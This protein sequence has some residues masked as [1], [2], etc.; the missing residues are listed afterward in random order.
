MR[1]PKYNNGYIRWN[2]LGVA[3]FVAVLFGGL[4]LQFAGSD[5]KRVDAATG[6]IDALNVGTC[7]AT[8]DEVFEEEPCHLSNRSD[9]WEIRDE[10]EEVSTLYATY[11]HDPKTGWDEPRAILQDSDLLKVSISDPGRD[12]RSPVLV[13]GEGHT[14]ITGGLAEIKRLLV[15]RDLID[16]DDSVNFESGPVL[17]IRGFPSPAQIDASGSHTLNMSGSSSYRPMDVDGNIRFFGCV[18][19]AGSCVLGSGADDEL[20]DISSSLP[21]DEDRSSGSNSPSIAPWLVVNASVPADRN[22]LIYAM[23]YETSGLE[24]MVGGSS[25][26]HCGTSSNEPDRNRLCGNSP[27]N[28]RDGIG[29]VVYTR[30][31][32][33]GNDEL[34]LRVSSDGVERDVNLYLSETGLFTGRYEGY[35]RLTD[36][37]GDGTE[38]DQSGSSTDWGAKVRHGAGSRESDAAVIGVAS[39]PVTIEYRDSGGRRQS[40][41]IAIDYEPPRI[42]IDTPRH[43]SSSDDHSPDFIGSFEDYDSGLAQDSFRL[44]VDNDADASRNSDFALDRI[45]PEASV[46]GTGTNGSVSRR[47]DYI[48]YRTSSDDPFGVVDPRRLFDLG[49]DSCRNQNICYISAD[50]Y[51][52]GASSGRFDDSVRLRLDSDDLEFGVDFQAFVVDL[53]GNVGFSDS[54]PD[55]PYFINDLGVEDPRERNEPNVLGYYSAHIF[56]LDEKDPE[57]STTRSAT[58]YYGVDFGKQP[59]EPIADRRGVML[60]FDGPI[61]ASSITLDTFYVELDD[62]SEAEVVDVTVHEQYVFLKLRH[63]L[64]SD[65]TPFVGIA[66][67]ESVRDRAGNITSGREQRRVEANDGISPNLTITLSGGSGSGEGAEGPGQLTNGL[68]NIRVESDEPLQGAPRIVVVCENLRWEETIRGRKIEYDVDDFIA[69]RRGVFISKPQEDSGTRYMCGSGD[70]ATPFQ[71]QEVQGNARPGEVWEFGWSNSRGASGRLEDGRLRVVAFARDRSRYE[72]ADKANKDVQSWGAVSATFRLDRTFES[73]LKPSGGNVHPSDASE[74]SEPRP[75]IILEFAEST[76]VTLDSVTLDGVEIAD[77]FQSPDVNRFVYWPLSMARG[78]H[79]IEVEATDAAG[80]SVEFDFKFESTQRGDFVLNFVTGWNAI[81]LPA[82]PVDT[83]IDAVFTDPAIQAVVGWDTEGW[84]VAIRRDGVW[85]SNEMFGTLPSVRA[86]Y[87][88]WVKSSSF[89]SQRV[90]LR[91]PVYRV[92]GAVPGLTD[93]PTAAGWNFV[94]VIDI[95]GDQTEDHFGVTLRDSQNNPVSARDYLGANFIRAY[96]WDATFNRFEVLRP[97]DTMTIGDGVWVYFS[98]GTGIA[99]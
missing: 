7:L 53:A 64:A 74:V 98:D 84:R 54:D 43:L 81:S 42:T 91:G 40:L 63:E 69:N 17:T 10:V 29:D 20:T 79:E 71:L 1:I 14:E 70:D 28:E 13:L 41:R 88:Y 76:T 49:D 90:A 67:G 77:E 55:N 21:V 93:I 62:G 68:I 24:K 61:S 96:T 6:V 39:G 2:L 33:N 83:H 47:A 8:D 45:A 48:G 38:I 65:A 89:V 46:S 58:G 86:R 25:Y 97:S 36:A 9:G 3:I 94:G 92:E 27:A 26:Y 87:G 32:V 57:I 73:P 80:N 30:D 16:S 59:V 34:L 37:N 52:D 22:V 51:R 18:T 72:R 56:G 31:E 4:V 19:S 12:K 99:P 50:R 60:V 82:D 5:D 95:D 23:Y 15:N 11:A 35:I 66:A 85:E 75:F 44:V 78:E